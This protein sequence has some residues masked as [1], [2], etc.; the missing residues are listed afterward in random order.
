ML[1]E[2]GGAWARVAHDASRA[3]Y[4]AGYVPLPAPLPS[5]NQQPEET[6]MAVSNPGSRAVSVIDGLSILALA[7][8]WVLFL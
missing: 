4:A 3:A 2:N 7:L 5:S 1:G 8:A 6:F